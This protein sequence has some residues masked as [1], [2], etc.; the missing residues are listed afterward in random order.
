MNWRFWDRTGKECGDGCAAIEPLLSLYSD[1]M[2]S[3]A[4][5]RRAEAHLEDC[6]D[7]QQSL[8]WMQTTHQVIAARPVMPPPADLRARIA[9]AIAEAEAAK[10]PAVKAPV[11]RT[12][13][14]PVRR[15]LMLRPA[16]A[17]GLSVAVLVAIGGGVVWK[18]NQPVHMARGIGPTT[19]STVVPNADSTG[20]LHPSVNRVVSHSDQT[21]RTAE[22]TV[23]KD[24]T[25]GG[26]HHTPVLHHSTVNNIPETDR[27]AALPQSNDQ[28]TADTVTPSARS[29]KT[30]SVLP[31]KFPRSIKPRPTM[32]TP[33]VATV[34]TH[35]EKWPG[36]T[37]IAP[38]S[39]V[40]PLPPRVTV[41]ASNRNIPPPQDNLPE[42]PPHAIQVHVEHPVIHPDASP[43]HVASTGEYISSFV[44]NMHTTSYHP[45][46]KYSF[47]LK[48]ITATAATGVGSD[49][50]GNINAVAGPVN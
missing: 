15:P 37:L 29:F 11:V 47:A 39:P 12:P 46:A 5:A 48:G 34:V 43:A 26:A 19:P 9:R 28:N 20:K 2:A 16:L 45:N 4:E 32:D 21:M 36:K 33:K 41:E 14:R 50:S 7:C 6:A 30:P 10:A 13:V 3:P 25:A 22:R 31:V 18:S 1:G 40:R 42:A 27:L 49:R 24:H 23:P 17:Y 38:K 44:Q 8:R 35:D